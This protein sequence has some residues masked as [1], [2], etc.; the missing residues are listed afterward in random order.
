MASQ[1]SLLTLA[2]RQVTETLERRRGDI[3]DLAATLVGFD[4]T[5][6]RT[7][8]DGGEVPALQA[9]LAARMQ[10]AGFE[11]ELFVPEPD[12]LP[13]SRMLAAGHDMTGRPQLIARRPGTGDGRSLLLNGHVDVVEVGRREAWSSDPFRARL[14]AGRLYGRGA[15]DMKGGVAAMVLAAEVLAELGVPLRGDLSLN[16]VTDEESTGAGSLA[17]V[18]RG[19]HADGCLIPEPTSGQVWL[20]SRGVLLPTVEVDG[21]AGH[22]GLA[23]GDELDGPGVGAIERILPILEAMRGLREQWWAQRGPGETPGWIVPTHISAGEWIVTFPDSCSVQLHV[24]YGIGQ[25]DADGWGTAVEREVEARVRAAALADPWL[26]AHPPRVHWSTDVPSGT[27]SADEP[28]VRT[29]LGAAASLEHHTGITSQTTWID[30][31]TF[32]RSG[33]PAIGFGPGDLANAHTV[34]ES[35]DVSELVRAAQALAVCAMRFC[36][37]AGE[38]S[39]RPRSERTE[40]VAQPAGLLAAP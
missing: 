37:V 39:P 8:A 23:R 32:S 7:G 16:T 40:G 27:I 22:T 1:P 2:E 31:I 20:G 3:V 5:A 9:L 30:A 26:A 36:G 21:R 11:V 14:S 18:A 24:T 38:R 35:I 19:L 6:S 4:T 13:A 10:S 28:I 15:C 12:D 33:T 25:A 17:C 34:D 29:A